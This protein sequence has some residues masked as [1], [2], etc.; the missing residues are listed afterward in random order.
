[1]RRKVKTERGTTVK[2]QLRNQH[3][4]TGR[5]A[6][7]LRSGSRGHLACFRKRGGLIPIAC[8]GG[9]AYTACESKTSRSGWVCGRGLYHSFGM[10]R[11]LVADV[12]LIPESRRPLS[13]RVRQTLS[14]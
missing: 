6:V 1:A 5:A 12:Q 4:R 11:L 9:K 13:R 14:A 10:R 8:H 3:Q 2:P 7:C